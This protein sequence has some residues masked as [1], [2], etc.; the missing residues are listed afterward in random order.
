MRGKREAQVERSRQLE[1]ALERGGRRERVRRHASSVRNTSVSRT[2]LSE[3]FWAPEAPIWWRGIVRTRLVVAIAALI[4]AVALVAGPGAVGARPSSVPSPIDP[5]QFH[6]LTITLPPDSP[7]TTIP[8]LSSVNRSAGWVAP[9]SPLSEFGVPPGVSE[10]RPNVPQPTV[11][12]ALAPTPRPAAVSTPAPRPAAATNV[13]LWHF[14]SN[15]SW[16]GP[17]FYGH[18]TACGVTLTTTTLGVAHRTLPCGTRVTL[19]N[20]A[21]GSTATVLV[22]DRGPYVT[23]RTWDMTG[24]L[25]TYLGHCYTGAM[26]WRLPG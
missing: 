11:L 25:C 6:A 17:G 13:G 24:G 10:A 3:T 7:A 19:R 4:A 2:G 22:I 18:R 14:D 9:D 8:T 16:Y 21:N 26:Y 12:A 1:R 20:P 15:V 23:G 5:A